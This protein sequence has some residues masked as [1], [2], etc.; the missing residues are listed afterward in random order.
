MGRGMEASAHRIQGVRRRPED[1][2]LSVQEMIDLICWDRRYV[3]VPDAIDA[4]ERGRSVFL[5]DPTSA[6]RIVALQAKLLCEKECKLQGVP[7]S[8]ALFD[9]AKESGYWTEEDDRIRHDAE[10]HIQFL[11]KKMRDESLLTRKRNYEKQMVETVA[12]MEETDTKHQSIHINTSEYLVR[13]TE[14]IT[15]ISRVTLDADG[16]RLWTN[17]SE[18]LR[19][20]VQ[21]S[22]YLV[23]LMTELVNETDLSTAEYRSLARSGEWRLIWTLSFKHLSSLFDRP[24]QD[25]S[26]RQKLLI[27]WSRVYDSVYDDHEKPDADVIEDDDRLDEWLANRSTKQDEENADQ[28]A[29]KKIGNLSKYNER[30]Q[31]MD[32]YHIEDCVC[33]A[34]KNRGKGLGEGQRHD[35]E[36]QWGTWRLYT[37]DEKDELSKRF[38]GRNTTQVRSLLNQEQNRIETDGQIDEQMLRGKR[39]RLLLGQASNII[40][41]NRR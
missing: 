2:M 33:G 37:D 36:C 28:K 16:K 39:S 24:I 27:Y 14:L 1:V 22:E 12:R 10:E 15:M 41:I 8:D 38:Y 18:F 30:A 40:P 19:M 29:N 7:T 11:E 17:E 34:I 35:L 31:F 3:V 6:D 13:E 23:Y 5:L 26:M 9:K 25:L 21:Y 32:G 4:P 20:R